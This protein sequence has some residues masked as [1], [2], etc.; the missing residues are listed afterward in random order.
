MLWVWQD[1]NVMKQMDLVLSHQI[2]AFLYQ[3]YLAINNYF[4]LA[5][6]NII[7]KIIGPKLKLGKALSPSF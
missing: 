7:V 5:A 6:I 4:F 3:K 1:N 2:W